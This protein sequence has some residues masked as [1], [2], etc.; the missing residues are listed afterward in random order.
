MWHDYQYQGNADNQKKA[1]EFLKLFFTNPPFIHA[2]KYKIALKKPT[3]Y[4]PMHF[5]FK[6]KKNKTK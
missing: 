6:I 3:D 2:K 5:Y 4:D 1:V